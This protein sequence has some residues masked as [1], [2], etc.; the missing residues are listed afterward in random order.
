MDITL[1]YADCRGAIAINGGLP[2]HLPEDLEWF[3]AYTMD[4]AVVMGRKTLETLPKP[5]AGRTVICLTNDPDY[6]DERC[7]FVMNSVE[8]VLAWAENLE[9]EELVIAGG[10]EI[11]QEFLFLANKVVRTR[12]NHTK[13][14]KR[15]FDRAVR[16]N[17]V[18][19]SPDLSLKG[20]FDS[21]TVVMKTNEM[22]VIEY[23][24]SDEEVPS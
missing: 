20:E 15:D 23:V 19:Y 17:E 22:V 1:L 11:Y 9:I 4:K 7:N 14:K 10:E 6:E 3:K 24:Y 5:L 8:D 2:V 13:I 21:A 16:R 12:I 18:Q